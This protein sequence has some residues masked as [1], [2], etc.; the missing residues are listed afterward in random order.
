MLGKEFEIDQRGIFLYN[1]NFN[2][3]DQSVDKMVPEPISPSKGPIL[4]KS[5][6]IDQ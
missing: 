2:W 3:I 6:T 4:T 1:D 5:M